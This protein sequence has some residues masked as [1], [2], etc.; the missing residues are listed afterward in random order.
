MDKVF[1]EN[2]RCFR[3]RQE[4][5]LKPITLLVGN[6]STGKTSFLALLRALWDATNR[7]GIPDFKRPPID[8]GTFEDI[9]Y[10]GPD[11]R[12]DSFET[13]YS[14]DLPK[15]DSS[16]SKTV[17]IV[18]G[19]IGI[20][21]LLPVNRAVKDNSRS[22]NLQIK[23]ENT[24]E[25]E[26]GTRRGK[27]NGHMDVENEEVLK[28]FSE[29]PMVSLM[30]ELSRWERQSLLPVEDSPSITRADLDEIHEMLLECN[31]TFKPYAG[32]PVRA[33]PV[34]TYDPI[35]DCQDDPEGRFVPNFLAMQCR[36]DNPY[37]DKIKDRLEKFGK[38][39]QLFDKITIKKFGDAGNAPFQIHV[40]INES[41]GHGQEIVYRN[42]A[43]VDYGVSQILPIVV[44]ILRKPLPSLFLLQQPEMHLH[45]CAQAAMGSFLCSM[46][47]KE[48]KMII[49]TH[50]DF[51]ME[52]I[53]LDIRD[54]KCSLGPE[55]FSILFFDRKGSEVRI[56]PIRIDKSGNVLDAPNHYRNFFM[57]EMTR[58][59]GL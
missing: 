46:A 27:W 52:R 13:G 4:V 49:E 47:S 22:I 51:L 1:F 50:S 45:P 37:R 5:V 44:H 53:M 34:R 23:N 19:R 2:F 41:T 42:L 54:G 55:D 10:N 21:G 17:S 15:G 30:N 57:H 16:Y 24:I 3:K 35:S 8:L 14:F 28:R 11:H 38:D 58:S 43:D 32:A 39:S 25:I 29:T 56:H 18:F 20:H 40:G 9:A 33:E 12:A 59:L 48:G 26:I 31:L 36:D 7:N 6:N